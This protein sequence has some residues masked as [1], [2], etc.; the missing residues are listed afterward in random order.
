M[1]LNGGGGG[2]QGRKERGGVSDTNWSP[3]D[4]NKVFSGVKAVFEEALRLEETG[5][6]G[7]RIGKEIGGRIGGGVEGDRKRCVDRRR[8]GNQ[9]GARKCRTR[10]SGRGGNQRGEKRWGG[11]Q[12]RSTQR[13]WGFAWK[14]LGDKIARWVVEVCSVGKV[15]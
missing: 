5:W 2:R 1:G 14:I 4:G 12:E 15:L 7:G 3:A 9:R 11:R 13:G 6:V 10:W 8:R